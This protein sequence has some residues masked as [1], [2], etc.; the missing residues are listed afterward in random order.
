MT[1]QLGKWARVR[2]ILVA[3]GFLLLGMVVCGRFLQLQ[4][5]QGEQLR[6]RA[7][8]EIKK[9][10]PV[11][12]VR[13]MILDSQ[14][15]E[16]AVSTRVHSVVAHPPQL[17]NPGFLSR[18]LA[19]ILGLSPQDLLQTLTRA[20]PFVFVK[21]HLTP[22]KEEAFRAWQAKA[23]QRNR[24]NRH[25][26]QRADEDW[27]YLIPEGR[28]LY[29]Q[30]SLAGP[31]LGFCNIDEQGLEGLEH[32]FDTYLYG[33][34]KKAVKLVDARGRIV[35]NGEKAW[36]PEVMG[37]NLVLT[38]NRTLQYIAE[39]ELER[40]VARWQAAGGMVLISR[41]QT[42]EIL[43]MAQYPTMDPNRYQ[44]YSEETRRNR[45]ITDAIEP[46]STF[47]VFIV[48]AALDAHLVK[49][50]DRFHCENGVYHLGAKEVIHDCHPYGVLT[51]QQII[52]KSSNI[53]AAKIAAKL[54]GAR[55]DQYLRA[56]GFGRPTG[57][58][59]PGENAGL[60]KN[61]QKIR[62]PLDRATCAFGQGVSVTPL[63][64]LMAL[65]AIGNRGIL[66]EPRLVKEI[67]DANGTKIQDYPPRV[68]R[69][70][71][72]EATASQML[73]IMETV[74]QEG[75]TAKDMAP[76]GFT[77]AGKTGTAQKVVG[78]TYSHNKFYSLFMALVPAHEPVLAILVIID[79]PK[80]AVYG[81]VVAAPIFR[82]IAVQALRVLG[83]YPETPHTPVLAQMLAPP[84]PADPVPEGQETATNLRNGGYA[85]QDPNKK[86]LSA[87]VLS[88]NPGAVV[89]AAAFQDKDSFPGSAGPMQVMPDLTGL[90]IR[91]ALDV[92]HRAG[93]HCHFEGSGRA[94]AQDPPPG[95]PLSPGGY[96]IVRFE[97][98]P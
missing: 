91:Q 97:A 17:R 77:A 18:E 84:A 64:L 39:K 65:S 36:D 25:V 48:A 60:L 38:L 83:Y 53:G 31:V 23:E 59:F 11:L 93:L 96:C 52:Q 30:Q 5:V 58:L 10:F 14:G 87:P 80:G 16:L 8:Q 73:A 95:T 67:V 46:G 81:G 32:Q 82:D 45:L 40:G 26:S 2:I 94:V 41:P 27:V 85:P 66:M 13:G 43:A 51:V 74:T 35:I 34:P 9:H 7:D 3:V 62:S 4:L 1:S 70:V 50:T 68:K 49:P 98:Q 24:K 88:R 71:L 76:P 29:P 78:R 12:P 57:I 22:E 69:R 37:H 42:G 20:R 63:Q 15:V 19:P 33:K 72:S 79:E 6:E 61:F 90:T 54:G 21:R 92:L 75:G 56:F 47:K 44:D 28:R 55:M 86:S 89:Q